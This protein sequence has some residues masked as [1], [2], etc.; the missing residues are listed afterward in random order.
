M[1][2]VAAPAR[3]NET[4]GH[5]LDWGREGLS[6][7]ARRVS[8]GVIEAIMSDEDAEGHLVPGRAEMCAR[9]VDTLADTV[10]RGSTDLRRGFAFL[11]VL[12]EWLPLFVIGAPSRMTR[13][14]LA[15]RVAY[16]EALEGSR[17]GWL[18]MLLIAFKVPLCIPAFEEGE[19]LADTGFD[20]PS[21]VARRHLA[22]RAE[23]AA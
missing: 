5:R 4:A 3:R 6:P 1:R 12:M 22:V 10:G 21:T 13:L 16:L 7:F 15:R 17:I 8:L 11:C 19:E 9:A 20:R 2:E 14:P 18:S 23:E